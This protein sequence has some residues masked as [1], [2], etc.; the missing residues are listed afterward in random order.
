MISASPKV[1]STDIDAGD[2]PLIRRDHALVE[3]PA[4]AEHHR[5]RDDHASRIGSIPVSSPE[6]PGDERDQDQERA[7][8][9]V[10]DV[11]DAEDQRQAGRHQR[12][13]A[14][15]EQPEDHAPAPAASTRCSGAA[16]S[17]RAPGRL[18]AARATVQRLT[19]R[20]SWS[21][22]VSVVAASSGSDDL[23]RRRSATGR[24]GSPASAHPSRPSSAGRGS[25]PPRSRAASRR[26]CSGRSTP[27]ASTA[28]WS[29][30]AAANASAASS[31]GMLVVV[32]R[33]RT[34]ATN[35]ALLRG[36]APSR[37]S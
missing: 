26:A 27:T 18:R 10:D 30:C 29:T 35:S 20:A 1:S 5:R 36:R 7:L 23:H 6:P 14:A 22:T 25:S 21:T 33:L 32:L 8:G 13:D 28:A 16:E 12:V 24:A 9:D 34:S 17:R 4:D 37:S 19:A 31:A 11:H 15:D 3:Q 2:P